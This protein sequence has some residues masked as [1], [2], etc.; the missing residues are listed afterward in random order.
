ML[1]GELYNATDRELVVERQH[2]ESQLAL[3]NGSS[4]PVTTATN[5]RPFGVCVIADLIGIGRVPQVRTSVPG[6][7]MY[8]LD[9]FS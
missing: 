6:P 1:R 9:C 8:F 4:D 7:K 2:V 5:G 3:L